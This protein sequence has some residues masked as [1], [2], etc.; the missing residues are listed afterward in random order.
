M[1]YIKNKGDK[2]T[3]FRLPNYCSTLYYNIF[4]VLED[5]LVHCL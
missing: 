1:Y 5:N 3:E 4:C 2:Y